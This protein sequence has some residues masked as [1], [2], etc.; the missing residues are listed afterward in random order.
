MPLPE[1]HIQILRECSRD[2]DAFQRLVALVEPAFESQLEHYR[3]IARNFPYGGMIVVDHDLRCL[4]ADGQNFAYQGLSGEMLEGKALDELLPQDMAAEFVPVFRAALAGQKMVKEITA[5]SR[6][7]QLHTI[8]L[9]APPGMPRLGMVI[10]VDVTELR[11]ALAAQ[12]ETQLFLDYVTSTI[13]DLIYVYDIVEERMVYI[14]R[15]VA[16]YTLE[17]ILTSVSHPDD[18]A[19]I[20]EH[21]HQLKMLPGDEMLEVEYRVRQEDG[22]YRWFISRDRVSK[23][24]AAGN[25]LQLSGIAR[26]ITEHKRLEAKLQEKHTELELFFA[27]I[28]DLWCIADTNGYF[29]KLSPMWESTLGYS[30]EELMGQR[31]LDFVHPDDVQSTLD[32]ISV[33]DAQTPVLNF[34]NRYRCKDGSYRFIE[35]RSQPHGKLIYAAARDVTEREQL[36]AHQFQLV[37]IVESSSDAIIGKTLDGIITSWNPA[38]E[39]M[40]GYSAD[41]AIGQ[42]IT[43]IMPPDRIHE[44]VPFFVAIGRGEAIKRYETVRLRKDGSCLD[45]SLTVSPVKDKKGNIVGASTLS[46]DITERKLARQRVLE[47]EMERERVRLLSDFITNTSHELRTPLSIIATNVYLMTHIDDRQQ[48]ETKA[49]QVEQQIRYLATMID[50][51]HEMAKLDQLIA[52]DT[53]PI[54][55]GEMIRQLLEDYSSKKPNVTLMSDLTLDVPDIMG[56][57][58]YICLAVSHLLD[59]AVRF[60]DEDGGVTVRTAL[61][62]EEVIIE[63]EDKGIGIAPEH[64]DH[65]FEHFYKVDDA[66]TRVDNGVGMGLAIVSRI[67]ALHHGRVTVQ[68]KVGQGS[69]F[70]LHFPLP[71]VLLRG[72]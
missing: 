18:A 61:R 49:A 54:R 12:K 20:A 11:Q 6:V 39:V 17:E 30:L 35:W 29:L 67:M 36:E 37:S 63:V 56:D 16:G 57:P 3:Q 33:L 21:L 22:C 42:S 44:L 58:E 66:R 13:P 64:L 53:V 31:Y 2:E 50:E 52:L 4:V 43:L 41:E 8:P 38:A 15:D 14:N 1:S 34:I 62:G 68:S 47:L 72:R 40:Y 65:I 25:P 71:N 46:Q 27:A 19:R 55:S 48:R 28:L 7:S 60:S 32:A 51:L 9:D 70:S 45:V 10:G 24:D 69:I 59:N 5:G 23:R 26:D